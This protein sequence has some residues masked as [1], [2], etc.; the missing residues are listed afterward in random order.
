MTNK[1]RTFQYSG[2][3]TGRWHSLL[4]RSHVLAIPEASV[5]HTLLFYQNSAS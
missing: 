1:I 2:H 5:C 4:Y 3:F